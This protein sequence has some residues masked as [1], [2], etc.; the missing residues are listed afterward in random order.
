M[1]LFTCLSDGWG[2]FSSRYL[3]ELRDE[4]GKTALWV[5]GL[6]GMSIDSPGVSQSRSERAKRAL[7]TALAVNEISACAS[8]LIP[9]AIPQS[10]PPW[11]HIDRVSLW[12]KTA[13]LEAAVESV[14]LP[15]RVSPSSSRTSAP[16]LREW[17]GILCRG[18]GAE[19]RKLA[20]LAFGINE[21][22]NEEDKPGRNDAYDA[23]IR[24]AE[25]DD[26]DAAEEEAEPE[27]LANFFP[28][29]TPSTTRQ[30]RKTSSSPR[31]MFAKIETRRT[32]A[33]HSALSWTRN[34]R[35]RHHSDRIVLQ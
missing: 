12:H 23:R 7:N 16:L 13:L 10:L 29:V 33:V 34:D 11:A 31:K 4:L 14:L 21:A 9:L 5:F 1:Q 35:P 20:S 2:G 27:W 19:G 22:A 25:P 18:G 28:S 32:A 3:E 24:Q 15:T 6:D 17:E 30:Q 26:L 8:A